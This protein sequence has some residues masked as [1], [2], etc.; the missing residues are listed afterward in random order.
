MPIWSLL[1]CII[2]C[3]V[4]QTEKSISGLMYSLYEKTYSIIKNFTFLKEDD[5]NHY[6]AAHNPSNQ[7]KNGNQKLW[8]CSF[9][10]KIN[11]TKQIQQVILALY[12][13]SQENKG[14]HNRKGELHYLII[15]KHDYFIFHQR[16][17][18]LSWVFGTEGLCLIIGLPFTVMWPWDIPILN[19][20]TCKTWV[21]K[22]V[23]STS[24][25]CC[26][27]QMMSHMIKGFVNP[28]RCVCV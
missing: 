20:P 4:S 1:A 13:P 7:E 6:D 16:Y 22:L 23:I 12:L 18:W 11:K 19:F 15:L 10:L 14:N 24:W 17:M 27:D 9:C 3:F 25:S 21:M 8:W 26:V 28:E 2:K 5:I